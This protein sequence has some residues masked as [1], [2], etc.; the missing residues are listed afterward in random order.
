[1][2]TPLVAFV[3]PEAGGDAPTYW[4]YLRLDRPLRGLLDVAVD[5]SRRDLDTPRGIERES[6]DRRCVGVAFDDAQPSLAAL[7]PGRR[8]DVGIRIGARVTWTAPTRVRLA[9]SD[10]FSSSSDPW[11]AALGCR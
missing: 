1:M 6:A 11:F 4:V 2:R 3:R 10:D 9:L 8:V 7:R 5:G